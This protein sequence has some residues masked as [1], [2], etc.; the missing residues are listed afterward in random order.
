MSLAFLVIHTQCNII[1]NK[2]IYLVKSLKSY[3]YSKGLVDEL[4]TVGT[5]TGTR[6]EREE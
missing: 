3:P 6:E 5:H 1:D 4:D 2:C